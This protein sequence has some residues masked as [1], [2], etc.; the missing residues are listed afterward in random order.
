MDRLMDC[1]A[2]LH[3]RR[4]RPSRDRHSRQRLAGRPSRPAYSRTDSADLQ[5]KS[6]ELPRPFQCIPATHRATTSAAAAGGIRRTR[7]CLGLAISPLLEQHPRQAPEHPCGMSRV[8]TVLLRERAERGLPRLV[9]GLD[10]PS[11][12]DQG[13]REQRMHLVHPNGSGTLP[14]GRQPSHA[15]D[16]RPS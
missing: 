14:I 13:A 11:L 5:S 1:P 4:P 12:P 2:T 9:L 15:F 3:R 10:Q 8:P 7:Q 16:I 6:S